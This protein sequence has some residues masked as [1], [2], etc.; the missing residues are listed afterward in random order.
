M[1]GGWEGEGEGDNGG[2]EG[3][4]CLAAAL[5]PPKA[6][7]PDSP[8]FK[9]GPGSQSLPRVVKVGTREPALQNRLLQAIRNPKS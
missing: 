6:S 3:Q 8:G 9:E 5:K 4:F 1:S 7:K 2:G